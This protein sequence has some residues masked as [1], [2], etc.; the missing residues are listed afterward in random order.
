M[1]RADSRCSGTP[2]SV[3]RILASFQ[4]MRSGSVCRGPCWV[5]LLTC[6][7]ASF[8]PAKHCSSCRIA[9]T[10][11]SAKCLLH[12]PKNPSSTTL[13]VAACACNPSTAACW[14]VSLG[15]SASHRPVGNCFKNVNKQIRC[16]TLKSIHTCTLSHTYTT[17]TRMHTHTRPICNK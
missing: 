16:M 12:K 15:E 13:S 14:P 4:S 9:E 8:A 17:H 1:W 5:H 2:A 11:E 7:E 6:S 10:A 3:T